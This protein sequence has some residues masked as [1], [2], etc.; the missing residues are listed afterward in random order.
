MHREHCVGKYANTTSQ[1]TFAFAPC[2]TQSETNAIFL[3]AQK[4][5]MCPLNVNENCIPY[6]R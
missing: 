5:N 1:F 2:P 6:V 4:L 3:K